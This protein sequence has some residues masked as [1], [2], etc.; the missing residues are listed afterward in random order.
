MDFDNRE[1]QRRE[2]R[3]ERRQWKEER[4]R[5]WEDRMKNRFDGWE[6]RRHPGGGNVWTGVFLLLIGVDYFL[7]ENGM[8]PEWMFSWEMFLVGLGFFLG[9]R[10]G[11]RGVAWFILMLIGG[12]F[13]IK[14]HFAHYFPGI[15][16]DNVWPLALIIL[17]LF[18]IFRP[19]RHYWR[20][21]PVDKK[22][23]DE[24]NAPKEQAPHSFEDYIDSTSIFGGIKKNILSKNFKG[25]DITNIMGGSEIDLSQADINGTVTIDL[26]QVFG[27]TKLI[28]PSNW[29]VKPQMAAVFG[30]VEDKRSAH[31]TTPDPNKILIL[32]GTSVF[33][34]IEIRS[35]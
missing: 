2:Q 10:H 29:Q 24:T 22:E 21:Y 13:L 20:D 31:N 26:T 4:R 27:G 9:I 3:Q 19:R 23:T 15:N 25:G 28:V 34:G 17:G 30:G 1:A 18:I 5:R 33:G 16:F 8:V 32:D 11:F 35:Y 7:A 14:E 6:S 12:V